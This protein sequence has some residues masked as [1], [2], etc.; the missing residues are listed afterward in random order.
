MPIQQGSA[1]L[2]EAALWYAARGW[3]VFPCNTAKSP[4]TPHG[5]H[6]A[7]C[8]Q[9]TIRAWWERWPSAS[10]GL[11]TGAVSG[12][13][14]VDVDTYRGG[15]E[16]L[17]ALF[18]GYAPFPETVQSLTG[19]GG[20]HYFFVHPGLRIPPSANKLGV[21]VDIRGDGGYVILPPSPHLSGRAYA[22]EL[23]SH[24]EDMP[25]APFPD[26]LSALLQAPAHQHRVRAG[27]P[28][29]AGTR[30]DTLARLAGSM[31]RSGWSAAGILAA[32]VEENAQHCQPPLPAQEVADIARSVA[33]YAPDA[34]RDAA[35]RGNGLPQARSAAAHTGEDTLPTTAYSDV[36]NG[37]MLVQ[38]HG[39]SLRYCQ[40]WHAWYIWKSTHWVKDR[41]GEVLDFARETI[42]WLG[43]LALDTGNDKLLKHAVKSRADSTLQNMLH[44]A[45][46]MHPIRTLPEEFDRYPW[47]INCPN[48]TV[49]LRSSILAPHD[50]TQLISKCTTTA[51]TS[52]APCPR[53]LAFLSRIMGMPGPENPDDPASLMEAH[54]KEA[55]RATA[56]IGYVQRLIGYTLVGVTQE[57]ILPITWGTGDNG[58]STFI[59]VIAD[60]LGADY[61]MRTPV[62]LFLAKRENAIPND[63]ARLKGVRFAYS[64][65]P[66]QNRRLNE[67]LIKELTGGDTVS[68]RFMRGEFFTFR[69]ECTLWLSTNL[70]PPTN[71]TGNALWNRIKLIP[72]TVTIPKEEQDRALRD[73]LLQEADGILSW[74][75][76][77][78]LDWQTNGLQEPED[79]QMATAAYR[80]ENDA[81]GR[82][83]EDQCILAMNVRVKAGD[84]YGGF[85][86]WCDVNGERLVSAK[87]LS[88]ALKEKGFDSIRNNGI[89]YL[90]IRLTER[91]E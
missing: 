74:A 60:V 79:V 70:R 69:P 31:R 33:R 48:G 29:V 1:E 36:F 49:D 45:G 82:F 19:G 24:P 53:W 84:L 80:S 55:D 17:H 71:D 7:T 10:I 16:S 59:E 3:P 73:S 37:E 62:E 76:R 52:G 4:R 46:T 35:S 13:V 81:L 32:L 57:K 38:R 67:S 34:P 63:V 2:L 18:M 22:W 61:A 65:E 75:V 26:W 87:A 54:A 47:L 21:G 28:I 50:P 40:E 30:N 23:S 5:F 6:D 58:K 39:A 20:I 77:G 68:A 11:P 83:I 25:L 91:T 44:Q 88:M 66:P 14:V 42:A 72:F 90:G 41:Q 51:Y 89:W 12:T 27:Q 78:C 64:S 8:E 85:K 9:D 43:H 15:D 86:K 56:M